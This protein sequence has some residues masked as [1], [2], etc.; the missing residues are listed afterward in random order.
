MLRGERCTHT[1]PAPYTG[2]HAERWSDILNAV[3]SCQSLA[4]IYDDCEG[5]ADLRRV[6]LHVIAV[7]TP[8]RLALNIALSVGLYYCPSEPLHD[9]SLL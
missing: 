8:R 9:R 5:D 3:S 4:H 6:L 1:G 7:V 2:E